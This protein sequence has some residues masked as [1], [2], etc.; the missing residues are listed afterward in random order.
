MLEISV[1]KGPNSNTRLTRAQYADWFLLIFWSSSSSSSSSKKKE[2]KKIYSYSGNEVIVMDIC[3]LY[4]LDRLELINM[5]A[6]LIIS[7]FDGPNWS[8]D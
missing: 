2:K 1:D 4:I 6:F 3:V 5:C 8:P 7:L